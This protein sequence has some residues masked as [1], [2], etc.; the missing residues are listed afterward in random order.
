MLSLAYLDILTAR[1]ACKRL[2]EPSSESTRDFLRRLANTLEFHSVFDTEIGEEIRSGAA[3]VAAESM[4][5]FADILEEEARTAEHTEELE[6]ALRSVLLESALLFLIAGF[7][8]NAAILAARL[9]ARVNAEEHLYSPISLRLMMACVL[10]CKLDLRAKVPTMSSDR[11][12][13]K[14]LGAAAQQA[15]NERITDAVVDYLHWLGVA[16]EV[17]LQQSLDSL[18]GLCDLLSATRAVQHSELYHLARLIRA[19]LR[20]TSPRALRSVARIDDE[21][22]TTYVGGRST[23]RAGIRPRPLLW[24]SSL[25]YAQSCLP[26]PHAS[27]VVRVPTGAGKSFVAELATVQA[28]FSG[29][30]LYLVP[31]NALAAQVRADLKKAFSLIPDVDIRAFLGGSEYTSLTEER[32]TSLSTLTVGVMTPEKCALALRL[33]PQAFSNCRLCIVD[34]CHLIA[35]SNRGALTELVMSHV[36]SLAPDCRF[37]LMSA[38]MS[39]PQDLRNWLASITTHDVATIDEDWRPTRSMR[40][41]VGIDWD[42]AEANLQKAYAELVAMPSRRKNR[43][44]TAGLRVIANLQGAW[45][46]SEGADYALIQM[47]TLADLS[48][49]RKG[50]AS[51]QSWTNS[52]AATLTRHFVSYGQSVLTFMPASKHYPFS[53]GGHLNLAT[54][55]TAVQDDE[56]SSLLALA[57][58]ELGVPSS[59]RSLLDSGVGVHTAALLESEKLA[60]ELAFKRAHVKALLATGTLAQGLNLPASVVIIAGTSIGDRREA[61]TPDGIARTRAQILNALG[62]AGRAGFS[63]HGLGLIIPDSA[64]YVKQLTNLG[65]AKDSASILGDEENST[66]VTS[67]LERFL[68][69]ALNGILS[70]NFATPDELVAMSYLSVDQ[71]GGGIDATRVLRNTFGIYRRFL[72]NSN[73]ANEAAT[74]AASY[75]Q[76]LRGTLVSTGGVPEWIPLVA[77]R[78]G[79]DYFF[80]LR[81]AEAL[82]RIA[83]DNSPVPED[84]KSAEDLLFSVL[85][86]IPPR[87]AARFISIF[88]PIEG[89]KPILETYADSPSWT[90]PPVWVEGWNRIHQAV[91]LYGT[92]AQLRAVSE[93]FEGAPVETSS[94]TA[95]SQP[96]PRVIAFTRNDVAK[97][98]EIAGALV[99]IFEAEGKLSQDVVSNMSLFP[100]AVKHGCATRDSISWFRFGIRY[101]HPAHLLAAAFPI[102]S[103]LASDTDIKRFVLQTFARFVDGEISPDGLAQDQTSVLELVRQLVQAESP[104]S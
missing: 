3:F 70:V 44:F 31:T 92:G 55:G 69:L 83:G 78:T 90:P 36:L 19:A 89:F 98:G 20:A 85:P 97:F 81:I 101:R 75:L 93:T 103:E 13:P 12:A 46:T 5:L 102:P 33:S 56:I 53:V 59:V 6:Q 96:I 87:F 54:Q 77:Y 11:M 14:A 50:E 82:R 52:A 58:D 21:R 43:A 39:N 48:V 51:A 61:Q 37:L 27:A 28:M 65:A 35:E 94:R 22:Y 86:L 25:S 30:V 76:Q 45:L 100:L 29:W 41:I 73:T 32:I 47:P 26:G 1:T 8:S 88:P 15:I 95:G 49:N 84:F 99:A 34:E 18:N 4:S 24:Q 2:L 17:T 104:I 79:F 62:R 42:D 60:S 16:P 71:E 9:S 67:R 63:N 74:K 91:A 38:M 57:E 40:A 80:V 66:P 72:S 68:H 10:L 23:G 7:D 64:L